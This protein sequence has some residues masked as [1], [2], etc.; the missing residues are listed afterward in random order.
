MKKLQFLFFA[1]I[2]LF[3]VAASAQQA[4]AKPFTWSLALQ[5]V[6]TGDMIAFSSP[7]QSWTGEQFR[8]IIEPDAA[9]FAYVI[10]EG[11]PPRRGHGDSLLGL[12]ESRRILAF[13]GSG[14]VAAQGL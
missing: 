5:N 8:I 2:I 12:F 9:C 10:Y 6:K 4:Q 14:T 11:P 7:V 3:P 1:V 13:T